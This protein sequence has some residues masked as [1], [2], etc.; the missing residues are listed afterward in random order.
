MRVAARVA[1]ERWGGVNLAAASQPSEPNIL[2]AIWVHRRLVALIVAAFATVGV[3]VYLTRPVTYTAEA[4]A[5]LQDPL[6]AVDGQGGSKSD[7]ARY[8]ADQ[9]AVLKSDE[10]LA[11]ASAR[12]R[13]IEGVTPLTPTELQNAMTVTPDQSSSYVVVHMQ[14]DNALTAQFAADSIIQAYR[15]TTQNNVAN[16][17][18]DQ[19][20][21]LDATIAAVASLMTR[22]HRSAAQQATALALIQQLRGKRNR[23]EIDGQIAGDGISLFSPAD[24]GKRQSAPLFATLLIAVVLGCLVGFGAA[25]LI[26]AVRMRKVASS[27]VTP[28]PE[29]SEVANAEVP[30]APA[31]FSGQADADEAAQSSRRWA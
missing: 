20:R 3:V 12:L 18:R 25:Y 16:R 13:K 5:L 26:E 7:A 2:R 9:V 30:A 6:A 27:P 14:A 17:T 19:L 31:P 8:I 1:M 23:I 21:K 29:L 22:T 4:G 24:R 28:V 10:V 11:G 15:V